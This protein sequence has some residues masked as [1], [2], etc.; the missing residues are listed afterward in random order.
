MSSHSLS[1]TKLPPQDDTPYGSRSCITKANLPIL[2][3]L[4]IYRV[5][6]EPGCFREPHWHANC[7]EL[8]YCVSG[9][10]FITIFSTGN[11]HDFFVVEKGDMFFVPSGSI[12]S[13]ENI[14]EEQ[15]QFILTFSNDS[16]EE[17][18]ISGSVGCMSL[19]V[20]GNIWR[21]KAKELGTVTRSLEDIIFGKSAS[22]P[23]IPSSALFINHYKLS[24][25][26]K[27]PAIFNEFGLVKV[28]RKD[29]WPVLR[30]QAM[31]SLYLHGNGMREPHWHPESVE[32]GYVLSGR[33]RMT[34]KHPG[35]NAD[36]YLLE[37][38]DVY[39][40]PRAYPH[41]IENLTDDELHFLVFFNNPNVPDIGYT[42]AIPAFAHRLIEPVLNT[43]GGSI[44]SPPDL[45]SDE[46]I[47][48][49]IN[50]VS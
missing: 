19:E 34:V 18:G 39:F 6:I 22:A 47:V 29:T 17:F 25:E 15:V 11:L 10:A 3:D 4:S 12:H 7:D 45:P 48:E 31:Y 43:R 26:S 46:L 13:I 28:A 2:E 27:P 8:G 33:S 21:R 44:F 36:T 35:K 24:L 20:L 32:M 42:G 38:G 16:P 23:E 40:V 9:K 1:L 50:P 14:G 5:I 37:P 49:K 30:F 41:H